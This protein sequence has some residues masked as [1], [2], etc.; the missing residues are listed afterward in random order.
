M[1]DLTLKKSNLFRTKVSNLSLLFNLGLKNQG[2]K[3]ESLVLGL[4]PRYQI[5]VPCLKKSN[6]F[7]TKVSKLSPL[8]DLGLKNQPNQGLKFE[9][10][11]LT[12]DSR[13]QPNQGIKFEYLGLKK[14]NFS[15]PRSQTDL[16]LK[17][18]TEQ[19]FWVRT[20]EGSREGRESVSV[21]LA[22]VR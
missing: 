16:E 22:N 11:V 5:W 13:N 18:S 17:K 20:C 3:F 21:E 8:F 10:L 2:L 7:W 14:S 12:W 4:K 19:E 1:F 9:S 6:F 15:K